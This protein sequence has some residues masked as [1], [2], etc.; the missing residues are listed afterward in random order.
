MYRESNHSNEGRKIERKVKQFADARKYT[1][2]TKRN[3]QYPAR[4]LVARKP[5]TEDG[6]KLST[7]EGEQRSDIDRL[8]GRMGHWCRH[9]G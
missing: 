2:D 6:L 5:K 7:P 9:L 1:K 8:N 3:Q 4:P